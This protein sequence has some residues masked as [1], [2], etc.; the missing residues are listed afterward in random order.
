[1]LCPHC[2]TSVESDAVFCTTCGKKVSSVSASTVF[3]I[4]IGREEGCDL[5]LKSASVSRRHARV[6]SENN[7][8]RIEDLGSK[9][10]ISVNGRKVTIQTLSAGD[11]IRIANEATLSIEALNTLF[12]RKY[13]NALGSAIPKSPRT[14]ITYGP[15]QDFLPASTKQV[16][17]PADPIPVN[18]D[19]SVCQWM[20]NLALAMVP[21]IGIIMLLVWI[22]DK[23]VPS[24]AAWAK[25]VL[26]ME[27]V[28]ICVLGLF[29]M[30]QLSFLL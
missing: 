21:L 19:I 10:G 17:A 27:V 18:E 22:K 14:D 11:V 23:S 25:L 24:R 15:L 4:T 12:Q 1:M 20:T 13:G 26:V 16:D 7:Q 30:R 2:K 6:V 8:L 5:V 28:F 9:N 29:L 3:E